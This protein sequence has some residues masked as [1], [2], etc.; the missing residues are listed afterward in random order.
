MILPV[1]MTSFNE[2]CFQSRFLLLSHISALLQAYSVTSLSAAIIALFTSLL[3][4]SSVPLRRPSFLE[5]G[6]NHQGLDP[7]SRETVETQ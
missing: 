2:Y 3:T 6:S 7:E 1:I 5:A 4:K